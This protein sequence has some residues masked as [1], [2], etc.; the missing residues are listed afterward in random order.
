MKNYSQVNRENIKVLDKNDLIHAALVHGFSSFRDYC[1]DEMDQLSDVEKNFFDRLLKHNHQL[2][3]FLYDPEVFKQSQDDLYRYIDQHELQIDDGQQL[4][5]E[6][7]I[8]LCRFE[9]A[10]MM[11]LEFCKFCDDAINWPE[12][13]SKKTAKKG[14]WSHLHLVAQAMIDAMALLAEHHPDFATTGFWNG[15]ADYFAQNPLQQQLAKYVVSMHHIPNSAAMLALA[16]TLHWGGFG[17]GAEFIKD[18]VEL[19]PLMGHVISYHAKGEGGFNVRYAIKLR[20]HQMMKNGV[21][22]LL[23]PLLQ[24]QFASQSIINILDVGSGPTYLG[25]KPMVDLLHKQH[26]QIKLTATDMDPNSLQALIELQQSDEVLSDVRY[27]DL[28]LV[29]DIVV[30]EAMRNQF[31]MVVGSLVLHQTSQ[32][33]IIEAMRFFVEVIEPGGFL[34]SLDV[35]EQGYYQC[36]IMPCNQVDREGFVPHYRH[37]PFALSAQKIE[38]NKVKILYPLWQSCREYPQ[39]GQALC[40]TQIFQVLEI[41]ENKLAQLQVLWDKQD[42]AAAD[43]LV[44]INL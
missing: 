35:G 43:Q 1:A 24:K 6:F 44:G 3:E 21:S 15:A 34:V 9:L 17:G 5:F 7:M 40:A 39:P 11:T 19:Q 10:S 25:A 37:H 28:T 2:P 8:G 27:L 31:Q 26:K 22:K 18:I 4:F 33:Q 36:F 42:Y 23:E 13:S 14:Y 30:D 29:K 20:I 41:E 32:Q 16:Q 12:I 38:L